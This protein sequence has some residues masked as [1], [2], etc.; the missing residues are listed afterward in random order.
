M[1]IQGAKASMGWVND[2]GGI[3]SLGGAKLVPVIGDTGSTLEGASSAMERLYRDPEIVMTMGSW[4]GSLTMAST[5][6]SERVGKP[7]FSISFADRL[8]AR[9]LKWG[10]YVVPPSSAQADLGLANVL[11]LAKSA[12]Q[13]VKTA[14][15]IGDNNV[16]SR[17][18]Y[19]GVRKIFPGLGVKIIGEETWAMATLTDA[20]PIMQ[21]VKSLNPDIAIFQ[22]TAISEA[23]M[24][25]MKRKELGVTIPFICNGGW[26]I[27]PSY[28]QAGVQ[29][30]EGM[31]SI[32][33]MYVSQVTPKEWVTRSLE[34]CKK[35]YS[36]EPYVSQELGIQPWQLV[37]IMAEVLERAASTDPEK[38]REAA[39]KMDI[40]D[41]MAT[42]MIAGQGMAFD[43]N[44]RIAKKYWEVVL[45]QWQ[46]GTPYTIFPPRHALSKAIWVKK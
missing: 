10:F 30:L 13:D 25:L 15:I 28:R 4:A 16:S 1:M 40:H 3:K 29:A 22:S 17:D 19:D 32:M 6:V 18:F 11:K 44:G 27:D 39:R 34:Q 33:P 31:V 2:N 24:C 8:S 5:E 46:G 26:A 38:I 36:N 23:Q 42:K 45:V 20:T 21:K 9:G 37:P 7:H 41:V 14:M 35:E 12:G 43:D